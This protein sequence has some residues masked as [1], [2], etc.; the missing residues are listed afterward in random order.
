[1]AFLNFHYL[2]H[3]F[4]SQGEKMTDF[5]KTQNTFSHG[6]V[7]PEFYSHDNIQGLSRLENADVLSGG[8]LSRRS[9]LHHIDGL[10]GPARLIP[11]SASDGTDYLIVLTDF[12]MYVYLGDN[13]YQDLITP[14]GY[15]DLSHLQYA[16]RFGT[17]IFVHRDFCP[18][19]LRIQ[20]GKFY[21][22]DFT[23]LRNDSDLSVNIPFV[24]FDDAADITITVTANSSGNNYATFTT[25]QDFWTPENVNGRLFLLNRQWSVVEYIDPTQVVAHTNG[26][27]SLPTGPISDWREAAFG[28]RRGWPCS[29]TFHQDRLVFG[30]SRDWPAGIWLSAVGRHTDFNPGTG[31]DDEAIFISLLS[32]QRQQI[33]TV[34]SSDN[35]QI[36]TNVGEWAISSKPLTPSVVDIKQHTTVGSYT[37][38]YLPPQKIEGATVFI[39]GNGH[40]I[41][42]L[43]LD[44][45]GENYNA[46]DLCALSKHLLVSP[47]DIAYNATQHR[48]YIVRQDGKMAVLNQNAALGIS[49]WGTYQTSGE[50]LSVA[51]CDNKTYVVVRRDDEISLEYF[52]ASLYSDCGK[53]GYAFCACG[54][55]LRISGHNTTRLRLRK[56][57]ARVFDTKSISLNGQ[58]ISLPDEIYSSDNTAGYSGDV[59]INLLGTTCE[60]T[61]P[62]W[63]IHGAEN[64][65]ATILS[66]TIHGCYSV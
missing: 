12:H 10:V 53:Y 6:E 18:Q 19:T 31:L 59:S 20:D 46:N 58:R 66:I 60:Y 27:Y 61:T 11:F 1:M 21:L 63:T 16:Q 34:V 35:L 3:V 62:I 44:E 48:L 22:S 8:G 9:G 47:I 43:S 5:I 26:S 13:R 39:S 42:E 7:S 38:R 30:G 40:D 2:I 25:N 17:M 54:L 33:C 50:F 64:Y 37:K 15:D 41:R 56:I 52:D 49:A 57:T 29:I 55:P 14:W 65:P 4:N 32:A 51:V 45:L 24:K 36:L 23:F 28:T